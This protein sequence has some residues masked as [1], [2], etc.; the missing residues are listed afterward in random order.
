[1]LMSNNI[2]LIKSAKWKHKIEIKK[3]EQKEIQLKYTKFV[4]NTKKL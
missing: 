2:N 1:M 3:L 4:N